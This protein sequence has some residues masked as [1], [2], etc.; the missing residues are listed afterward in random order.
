MSNLRLK[1][2]WQKYLLCCFKWD[3]D[4]NDVCIELFKIDSKDVKEDKNDE[5][6]YFMKQSEQEFM[7]LLDQLQMLVSEVDKEN[8]KRFREQE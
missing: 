6:Q 2:W 5:S 8:F 3:T 4:F 7:D 1:T